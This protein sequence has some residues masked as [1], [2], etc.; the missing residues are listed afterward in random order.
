MDENKRIDKIS[1]DSK[2]KYVI[3][4]LKKQLQEL[5]DICATQVLASSLNE[6]DIKSKLA[7]IDNFITNNPAIQDAMIEGAAD[8]KSIV[9]SI[10]LEVSDRMETFKAN[11]RNDADKTKI[12][13]TKKD[14]TEKSSINK[15][16]KELEDFESK[17]FDTKNSID[18]QDDAQTEFDDLSKRFE[19]AST[20]K[21]MKA[22]DPSLDEA[23]LMSSAINVD[24]IIQSMDKMQRKQNN[25]MKNADDSLKTSD[26]YERI[27]GDII[28]IANKS[29]KK[30]KGYSVDITKADIKKLN[31]ALVVLKT[32]EISG[33]PE[34]KD[35]ITKMESN[36]NLDSNGKI[37]D[38]KDTFG[39]RDQVNDI[40]FKAIDFDKVITDVPVKTN[41]QMAK[42]FKKLLS[43][44]PIFDLNPELKKQYTDMLNAPS[45]NAAYIKEQLSKYVGDPN[46]SDKVS[47]ATKDYKNL[48]NLKIDKLEAEKRTKKLD[49]LNNR[50]TTTKVKIFGQ[51]L[52]L[53]DDAGNLIDFSKITTDADRDRV[54]AE[55]FEKFSQGD[56]TAIDNHVESN[57][58]LVNYQKPS[59]I[60]RFLYKLNPLHW[61]AGDNLI[62]RREME[63]TEMAKENA[64]K[65]EIIKQLKEMQDKPAWFITPEVA[66]KIKD[67]D[68]ERVEKAV[69]KGR[70]DIVLN[71]K[72]AKNTADKVNKDIENEQKK[73]DE[74][75]SI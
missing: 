45:V 62:N 25:I 72:T 46:L 16:S 37:I 30:S 32:V 15:K 53:N 10:N 9:E 36:S 59:L 1:V 63:A 17:T 56:Q 55:L 28:H 20:Y 35:L 26:Y 6:A 51:E 43:T 74:E 21:D 42:D 24:N 64:V 60:S 50:Q 18:R 68:K 75:L 65:G 57:R 11:F 47:N 19:V 5:D 7:N 13:D 73:S 22:K 69:K 52:D 40:K 2:F 27:V 33:N 70:E 31:Q 23:K 34:I 54:V 3:M 29:F 8:V 38:L 44:E 49:D 66:Q 4:N 67:A 39:N 41:E 58:S 71:G 14:F 12:S 61:R 48:K